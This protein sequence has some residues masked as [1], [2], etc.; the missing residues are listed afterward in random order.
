MRPGPGCQGSI[1]EPRPATTT[2]Q[3][4]PIGVSTALPGFEQSSQSGRGWPQAAA[5]V[6]ESQ[7][8]LDSGDGETILEDYLVIHQGDG[9]TILEDYLVI[10]LN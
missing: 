6:P 1:K 3:Q 7:D 10:H 4:K 2:S 8:K 5:K 9:E